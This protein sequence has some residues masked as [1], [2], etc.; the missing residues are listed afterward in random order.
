[1]TQ[2]P[3]TAINPSYEKNTLWTTNKTFRCMKPFGATLWTS[4][5]ILVVLVFALEL[6]LRAEPLQQFLG[7]MIPNLGSRHL[8]ME[9]QFARLNR[10]AAAEGEVDCVF[11]GSS[12]VWL[13]INPPTFEEVFEL[14]T[15][16]P[17]RC[18]NFGIEALPTN[19]AADLAEVIVRDYHPSL[20]IYGTSARDY[21]IGR[22]EEESRVVS[23][24]P[25]LQDRLGRKTARS[26][27]VMNS[28]TVRY[29]KEMSRLL[30]LERHSWNSLS[31][32][33][34]SQGFLGKT[35]E[36]RREHYEAA[37]RDAAT[38]LRPYEIQEENLQ[39]LSTILRQR[40]KGVAIIVVEMPVYSQYFDYFENGKEDYTRFVTLLT[41]VAGSEDAILLRAPAYN[42]IP[43][44]GWWDRSHLNQ[45]GA[46]AF[47][48]WLAKHVAHLSVAGEIMAPPE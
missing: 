16:K 48:Q 28:Y 37:A 30:L 41:R 38:W 14:E 19:A 13:G 18:F 1:M 2:R 29:V 47:T 35:T 42:M 32:P 45:H 15:V 7:R 33:D 4:A 26:W 12:L 27:L 17:I 36:A 24:T 22:D 40:E 43:E 31:Q 3:V 9:E 11:L 25:W 21:A 20:L 44:D 10:F 34:I 5:I 23:D 39:S 8:Q 46:E 6:G